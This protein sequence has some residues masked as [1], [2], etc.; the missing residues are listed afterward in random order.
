MKVAYNSDI[1]ISPASEHMTIVNAGGKWETVIPLC[2][3]LGMSVWQNF[4]G[5]VI[6]RELLVTHLASETSSCC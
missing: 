4:A 3:C 6:R 2:P 5:P 1:K